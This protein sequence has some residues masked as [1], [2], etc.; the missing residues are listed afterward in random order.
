MFRHHG[1]LTEVAGFRWAGTAN[2]GAIPLCGTDGA[3]GRFLG[4][5]RAINSL[6]GVEAGK[7]ITDGRSVFRAASTGLLC[8]ISAA[9]RRSRQTKA[10]AV[11]SSNAIQR[12]MSLLPAMSHADHFIRE[13][14][15]VT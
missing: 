13:F 4:V 6:P 1:F 10:S 9:P 11:S 7:T 12:T 5:K 3:A 14:A 2:R 8:W 15:I